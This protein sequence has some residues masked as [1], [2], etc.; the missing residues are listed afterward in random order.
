MKCCC[1]KNENQFNKCLPFFIVG[2][3]LLSIGIPMM[4]AGIIGGFNYSDF[5]GYI[6][7]ATVFFGILFLFVW[8]F[9]TIPNLEKLK[10]PLD[11]SENKKVPKKIGK[12]T[13]QNGNEEGH[14]NHGFLTDSK[15][16][17]FHKASTNSLDSKSSSLDQLEKADEEIISTTSSSRALQLNNSNNVFYVRNERTKNLN[18][19]SLQKVHILQATTISGT[20]VPDLLQMN[21]FP[22]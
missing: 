19:G 5:I 17:L 6:G 14:N 15:S 20:C 16:S 7:G 18:G 21:A 1:S 10:L 9:I 8:Y 4:L 3:I 12:D 22:K 2:A 11:D 13:K